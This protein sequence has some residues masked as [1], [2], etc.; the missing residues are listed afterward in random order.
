METYEVTSLALSSIRRI[1]SVRPAPTP[2]SVF[3]LR[4]V[5]FVLRFLQ[6]AVLHRFR[7][8]K[9]EVYKVSSPFLFF[10]STNGGIKK[11]LEGGG[12]QSEGKQR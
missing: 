2:V 7:S 4:P 1:A 9:N 8:A 11:R 12:T 5:A 3:H 10:C 6:N